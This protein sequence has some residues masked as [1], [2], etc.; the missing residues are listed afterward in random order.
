MILCITIIVVTAGTLF[1][2]SLCAAAARGDRQLDAMHEH[3]SDSSQRH[4]DAS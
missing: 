3:R 4:I 1:A 2:L